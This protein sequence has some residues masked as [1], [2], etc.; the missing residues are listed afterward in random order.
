MNIN[1]N[2]KGFSLIEA[3]I[4]L[5]IVAIL[6]TA[7]V[8]LHLTLGGTSNKLAS[9]ILASRNRRVALSSVD[10]LIKN[11]DGM[12]RDI[13]GDCSDF[14]ATPPVL[15]LY[16]ADDTYLPGTCVENGGGVRLSIDDKNVSL[17]CYPNMSG[18]GH[19]QNCETWR[20]PATNIYY[21]SS[22]N[23]A[24]L[25]TSLSFS[26]STA[27]STANNFLAVSTQLSVGTHTNNQVN[28]SATSTA[29]STTIVRN[30]QASGLMTWWKFEASPGFGVDTQQNI[31]ISC[32]TPSTVS[33]L[34]SSSTQAADFNGSSDTC[35]NISARRIRF[36][37]SFSL[38]T[39]MNA[40]ARAVDTPIMLFSN[41][42]S[43]GYS[44]YTD[45]GY[46]S[47][48]VCDSDACEE[49]NSTFQM[50]NDTT[51]HVTATYDLEDDEVILYVY[52]K[53]VGGKATTT[54]NSLKTLVNH[55]SNFVI[56]GDLTTYF[57]GTLDDIRTYNRVLSP[58]EIWAIQSQG[59]I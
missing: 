39:W 23:V 36:N 24:V 48:R 43:L 20:Y 51:Y 59:E 30:E 34:V 28:L 25:N 1:K 5:A 56:A 14:D 52:Q 38:A 40:D 17:T 3:V 11:A 42:T 4:Y 55:A 7:V 19:F 6:L 53:G 16:F 2:K 54:V 58:E 15:A 41:L 32:N 37:N 27:T 12:L 44:F 50:A 47:L 29:T 22:P 35:Y 45:D 33:G 57:D 8:S 18:N 31:N 49:Y 13:N 21:L 9:N 10:Y 26:T 46:L